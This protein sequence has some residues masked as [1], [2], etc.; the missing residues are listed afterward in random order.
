M[1]PTRADLL[2]ALDSLQG[3]VG[4]ARS[5]AGND[6]NP[7]R[8]AQVDDYLKRA[9]DLCVEARSMDPPE[10]YGKSRFYGRDTRSTAM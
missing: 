1:K 6:R 10:A 7:N 5:A 2:A 8:A 9:H 4:M 3:L